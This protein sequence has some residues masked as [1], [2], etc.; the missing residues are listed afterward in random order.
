VASILN[1]LQIMIFNMIYQARAIQLTD[2]ENHRTDTDYED[3]LIV[4]LFVFQF[5]NSYTSFFFLAFIAQVSS[6]ALY[7]AL[8]IFLK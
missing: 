3:S 2:E 5:I 7:Y 6:N 4:K 1:T 8:M